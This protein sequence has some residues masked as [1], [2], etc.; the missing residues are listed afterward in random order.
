M[1]EDE[2]LRRRQRIIN[3]DLDDGIEPAG[4]GKKAAHA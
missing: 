4:R 2:K 3:D 1:S